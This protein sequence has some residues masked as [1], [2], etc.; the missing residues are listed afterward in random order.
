MGEK[1][2]SLRL[3]IRGIS[4][5]TGVAHELPSSLDPEARLDAGVK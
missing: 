2:G 3:P 1:P 4:S 5:S